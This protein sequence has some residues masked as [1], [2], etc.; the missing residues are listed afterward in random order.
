MARSK[1][2]DLAQTVTTLEAAASRV[3]RFK[4]NPTVHSFTSSVSA[5]VHAMLNLFTRMK[6]NRLVTAKVGAW[7][8]QLIL[9]DVIVNY[10]DTQTRCRNGEEA[11]ELAQLMLR[12]MTAVRT[13]IETNLPGVT[14]YVPSLP[15][16]LDGGWRYQ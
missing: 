10:G 6:I 16:V 13:I 9:A 15:C 5:Q 12:A 8:K 2:Q 4:P 7:R 14:G 3:H 11:Y 1:F